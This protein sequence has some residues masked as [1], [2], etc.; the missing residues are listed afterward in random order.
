[1]SRILS[2]VYEVEGCGKDAASPA[3]PHRIFQKEFMMW[4]CPYCGEANDE[5]G[6]KCSV[7]FRA[8]SSKYTLCESCST[9]NHTSKE[10][11]RKCGAKLPAHKI[12]T[13]GKIA[14][15]EPEPEAHPPTYTLK[16]SPYWWVKYAAL[17]VVFIVL[18]SIPA[19]DLGDLIYS[20]A[21][22][23]VIPIICL[24]FLLYDSLTCIVKRDP[25]Q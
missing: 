15:R 6:N 1:M 8:R 4:T 17:V 23:T 22:I 10:Y 7:C 9:R 5:S 12:R 16:R 11:C 20:W 18:L 21:A 25:E 19:D 2:G 14:H 13:D 3:C 24:L